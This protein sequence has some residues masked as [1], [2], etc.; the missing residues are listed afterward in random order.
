MPP[1]FSSRL[2]C[3]LCRGDKTRDLCFKKPHPCGFLK[4]LTFLQ[5]FGYSGCM[6]KK[7]RVG[8]LFGGKSAEHEV[9][10]RSARNVMDAIDK[11][12]Y[13]VVPIGI[14]KG[15]RWLLPNPTQ[16]L[17]ENNKFGIIVSEGS[18]EGVALIPQS[19]GKLATFSG[20][21]AINS[22]DVIFPV[23]HGTFG[24]DGTV[25]GLLKLADIQFVGA[26][27]LGS[28][29]G[30]DK[31]VQKRLLR[32]AGIPVANF[33]VFREKH[34]P[35]D[36][37]KIVAE[38]GSPFFVKPA[39][40]GS[41]IGISKVYSER[42]FRNAVEDA[43]QYDT[44][45]L[46]EQFIKGREIECAVLGNDDP[47]ASVPGEIIPH[48][49]FYSYEAKYIDEDGAG[50]EVPAKISEDTAKKIQNMAI[51]VF[52]ILSCEGMGRVDFF[53]KE[54]GDVVVNEINTIPGFTSI[55]MYPRLWQASGMPYSQLID[56][57]IQ[58]AIERFEREQKLKTSYTNLKR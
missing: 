55:S 22:I 26:G 53:L 14:T 43:F 51:A 23:L 9:S 8:I 34:N 57:L 37:Q 29:V 47:Q 42:E 35:T 56:R 1:R 21:R 40:L 48:R 58:L 41:S 7:I 3:S 46:A 13:E 36:Y 16:F 31:D 45:I 10:L 38:L 52:K 50:L 15:G 19:E 2:L 54:D 30:M 5:K 25:Q 18:A 39:N 49:D 11:E 24:E 20:D 17:S 28:A 27:V 44:K 32:D 12:K 33:L 4:K 6:D